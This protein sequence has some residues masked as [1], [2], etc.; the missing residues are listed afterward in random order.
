MIPLLSRTSYAREVA[1]HL[2]L[3]LLDFDPET[4][5]LVPVLAISR[6]EILTTTDGQ[7]SYT[8]EL[9]PEAKWNNGSPV[10]AA[11]YIFTLK[12][13]F[14]PNISTA[15]FR[16]YLDFIDHIEVDSSNLRRF[17]V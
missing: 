16:A 5:D 1:A 2:F 8:F 7:T 12:L 17:T 9:R 6:P 14:H 15:R 3:P 4:F 10:T 11:D 13:I